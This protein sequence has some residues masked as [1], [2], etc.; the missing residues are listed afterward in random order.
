VSASGIIKQPTDL[1]Y[2]SFTTG[3]GQVTL[4]A[5][6]Q[7]GTNNLVPRL[8][9]YDSTGTVLIASAGPDANYNAT[10]TTTMATGSYRLLVAD[11]VNWGLAGTTGA[12]VTSY[13]DTNVAAST[14]YKYR[15]A[16]IDAGG[17]SGYSNVAVVTTP[18]TS[19]PPAAPSSQVAVAGS[20]SSVTLTWQDSSNNELG[21]LIERSTNGAKSWTQIG[22]VGANVTSYTDTSVNKG[23]T[24]CYRVRAY[25]A[26]GNS[27]YS[28]VATVTTPIKGPSV[29]AAATPLPDLSSD[30][31]M[32]VPMTQTWLGPADR[33]PRW[34]TH[35]A[36]G[37]KVS[38]VIASRFDMVDWASGGWHQHRRVFGQSPKRM[39][40]SL[41]GLM[42]VNG[43]RGPAE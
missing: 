10:I 19:L 8:Q 27:V 3:T 6:V 16:A 28:N 13:Q 9:L 20:T 26:I 5:L 24:Y 7:T 41:D 2:F 30:Y 1:N 35:V 39:I 42:F 33:Q 34:K 37:S 32:V 4:S 31:E 43:P 11:G 21:F 36:N 15:V 17:A 18:T 38:P 29:I 14:T 12:N 40:S 23:K 25:N 22:Q